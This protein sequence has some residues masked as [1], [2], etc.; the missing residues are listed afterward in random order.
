MNLKQEKTTINYIISR[1]LT[2]VFPFEMNLKE[3]RNI[4]VF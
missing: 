2:L 1:V 3:N 4:V